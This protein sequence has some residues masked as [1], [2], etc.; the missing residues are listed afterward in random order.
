[1]VK[2]LTVKQKLV[3][4][5]HGQ[6]FW[7]PGSSP[8]ITP[9]GPL[10]RC[11]LQGCPGTQVGSQRADPGC[12]VSCMDPQLGKSEESRLLAGPKQL[13]EVLPGH[14]LCLLCRENN[15]HFTILPHRGPQTNTAGCLSSEQGQGDSCGCQKMATA[16]HQEKRQVQGS[17]SPALCLNEV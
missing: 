15:A 1:M 16:G 5:S 10:P 8:P 2:C 14:R 4:E 9:A 13:P 6:F 17:L 11:R 7:A 3:Q 12:W